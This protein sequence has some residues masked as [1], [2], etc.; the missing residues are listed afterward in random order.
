MGVQDNIDEDAIPSLLYVGAIFLATGCSLASG[1]ATAVMN[2]LVCYND[3]KNCPQGGLQFDVSPKAEV[4][5][6]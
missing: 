2:P 5:L 1:W 3:D 4:E 6:K